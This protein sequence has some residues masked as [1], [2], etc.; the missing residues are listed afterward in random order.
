MIEAFMMMDTGN[1]TPIPYEPGLILYDPETNSDLMGNATIT[2]RG[3]YNLD[4]AIR[5]FGK[6]TVKCTEN[7][8]IHIAPINPNLLNLNGT[9]WTYE[10]E[11]YQT[12]VTGTESTAFRYYYWDVTSTSGIANGCRAGDAGQGYLRQ[13]SISSFQTP[14]SNYRIPE[15]RTS[16]AVVSQYL[17][18]ALVCKNGR[19]T[20]Y[21]N[22]IAQ[23]LANG[24]GTPSSFPLTSW[25]CPSDAGYLRNIRH[26]WI[27]SAIL[28]VSA[29]RGRIR[30]S[31][32]ARYE[33]NYTPRALD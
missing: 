27:S 19:I 30:I 29:N 2:Y 1:D 5:F 10:Y 7:D 9:D 3:T 18:M 11:I 24:T 15:Q 17:Q 12:P 8:G 16:A 28:G 22:G 33:R 23:P 6:P 25:P 4:Q 21:V 20:N 14:T 31:D 13:F 26:G 32:F